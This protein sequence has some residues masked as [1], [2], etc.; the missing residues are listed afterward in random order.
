MFNPLHKPSPTTFSTESV[1]TL[2]LFSQTK[3]HKSS[4]YE[5]YCHILHEISRHQISSLMLD[6]AAT[7]VSVLTFQKI[8]EFWLILSE[9]LGFW[10][11]GIFCCFG[12]WK[13]IMIKDGVFRLFSL[14]RERTLGMNRRINQE[15][16]LAL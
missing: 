8:F 15:V 6:K 13:N 11:V 10:I 5:E 9:Y 14:L 7:H 2:Q 12:S 4:K 3:S 16:L 1:Y